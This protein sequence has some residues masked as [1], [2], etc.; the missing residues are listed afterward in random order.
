MSSEGTTFPHPIEEYSGD[1]LFA[2]EGWLPGDLGM[3]GAR[4]AGRAGASGGPAGTGPSAGGM[5]RTLRGDH[6]QCPTC[7]AYFNSTAAFDKHRT[8]AHGVDRRCLTAD[9]MRAKAMA[10][11]AGGWW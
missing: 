6:R 1:V 9:E 3:Q 5:K 11:N 10:Q 7:G 4:R 8:G 2:W